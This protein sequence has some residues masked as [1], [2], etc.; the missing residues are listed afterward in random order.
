M[1]PHPFLLIPILILLTIAQSIPFP[2]INIDIPSIPVPPSFAAPPDLANGQS[3]SISFSSSSSSSANG[4]GGSSISQIS[5]TC[6]ADAKCET[7]VNGIVNGTAV[8]VTSLVTSTV[9]RTSTSSSASAI[10]SGS[11]QRSEQ[12]AGL[13]GNGGLLGGNADLA[14]SGT[15]GSTVVVT[16]VPTETAKAAKPEEASSVASGGPDGMGRIMILTL[17]TVMGALIF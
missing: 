13:A 4:Q 7:H 8:G 14:A 1:Q 6:N 10:V 11:S 9:K 17:V 16:G 5:T 12:T 3:S 2:S 15:A